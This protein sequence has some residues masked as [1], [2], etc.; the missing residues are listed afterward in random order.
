VQPELRVQSLWTRHEFKAD[1]RGAYTWF[2]PDQT[3][4]LNRPSFT[5]KADG[6][7][8]IHDPM[9]ADLTARTLV[10]TDNPG[11]PNLQAGLSNLPVY[12]TFGG[13]AGLT[14]AFNR[15]EL[16]AKGDVE[17][18]VYQDSHLTDGTTAS[19]E[20]RQYNQY[21]GGFRAAY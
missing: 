12:A 21:S 11:S 5:G 7:I 15:L 13:G 18:T 3:P 17:R 16:T 10:A 6:R 14:K 8:D 1:L 20:D 19:N 2:S 9:H 4:S